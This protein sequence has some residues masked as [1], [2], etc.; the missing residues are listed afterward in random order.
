MLTSKNLFAT[1][2]LCLVISFTACSDSNT[3]KEQTTAAQPEEKQETSSTKNLDACTLITEEDAREVLG[4]P[5]T[6]GM[7]TT[8]MCQYLS[9][10]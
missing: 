6:R 7:N 5:V 2:I 4:A 8:S 10:A 1:L 3:N 9:A